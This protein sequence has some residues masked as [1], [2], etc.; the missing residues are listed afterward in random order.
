MNTAQRLS[1]S[2]LGAQ[3]GRAKEPVKPRDVGKLRA[4]GFDKLAVLLCYSD[5]LAR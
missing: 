1:Q 3:K 2:G 4:F 5:R